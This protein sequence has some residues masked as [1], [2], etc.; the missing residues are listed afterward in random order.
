MTPS[1][2]TDVIFSASA[3]ELLFVEA[4]VD[5]APA[6]RSRAPGGERACLAR[7][8]EV[9]DVPVLDRSQRGGLSGRA[10]NDAGLEVDP[11]RVLREPAA[12]RVRRLDLA[13]D[14][15]AGLLEGVE[16]AAGAIGGIAID[17]Q[18]LLGSG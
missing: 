5:R 7:P 8:G 10:D 13:H 3:G 1:V 9:G 14:L 18:R 4:D 15:H 16:H 17:S 12:R 11:E 2:A 6:G